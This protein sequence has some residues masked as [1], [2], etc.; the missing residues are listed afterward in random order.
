[1]KTM[2]RHGVVWLFLLALAFCGIQSRAQRATHVRL[3]RPSGS[4]PA[5]ITVSPLGSAVSR[6]GENNNVLILDGFT[7]REVPM[8]VETSYRVYQSRSEQLWSLTRDGMQLFHANEWTLHPIPEIQ[9]ELANN[10]IRQL[11]QINLLPAE[12]SH[13]FILLSDRLLDY[14][15]DTRVTGLLKLASDTK[16]GEFLEIQEGANE[17]I[18]ISG[19]LGFAHLPGP[20][21]RVTRETRWTEYLLPKTN[22]VNTLQRP[23]EYPPGT[24]TASA[25]TASGDGTRFIVQ[26]RGGEFSWLPVP[27]EKI[28][29]G[30]ASWDGSTW[31][32][33]S[34]ALFRIEQGPEEVRLRK[35]PISGAQYDMA[36]EANGVFWIASSEGLLRYAPNLWR[37]PL[38]LEDLQSSIHS[39]AFERGGSAMW[40]ASPEGLIRVR[41]NSIDVFPWPESLENLVPPRASLFPLNGGR[42]LIGTEGRPFLLNAATRQFV[43][44]KVPSAVQVHLLGALSDGRICAWFES[45]AAANADLRAFDG[46]KFEPLVVPPFETK[47]A[48]L[49]V[50]RETARGDLWLGSS[51]GVIHLRLGEGV[52]EY[53]GR[54]QGLSGER[55]ITLE[56]LSEGRMWCGTESHAYEYVQRRWEPRLTNVDRVHS[57]VSALGSV[58]VGTPSAIHRMVKDSW[59]ANGEN[60]GLPSGPVYALEQSLSG[61]L[62]AATS[63]GL[64]TFHADADPDPPKTW[65][66]VVQNPQTPSVLDPTTINFRGNDKWDYTRPGELLF[67]YKL[68]E[69]PWTPFSNQTSRTFQNLSSGTHVIEVR[70]MDRN[71]NQSVGTSQVEFAVIVPWFQDP[72]LLVV[73]VFAGCITMILAAYALMKHLQ[74]KRSYAEV[75]EIVRQRTGE[76]EKANQELLHSQKMRAIGTM[77]AGIAHDFNNILSI[78]KGSAQIIEGNIEDT[79]KI[80]TRVNRIQTVVEQGTTIVKALLG[81][82]RTNAQQLSSCDVGELLHETRRLLSDRFPARVRFQ[83]EL[84]HGSLQTVCSPEVVQQM[85]LNFILNAVEAM[86]GEGIVRLSAHEISSL[87]RE[88]V[89]EPSKAD[90]Y[91]VLT[92]TDTGPGIAPETLARIFEPFFTTKGFS[93]RRGTGLGLS[94]VY[95]LAKGLGYGIAV[96]SEIGKGSSFSILLPVKA[97]TSLA[98]KGEVPGKRA[99]SGALESRR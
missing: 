99:A 52:V 25:N 93:S 47:G 34:T 86:G 92:V 17:S 85:L 27:G 96:R 44:V 73:S 15:A 94:M 6:S 12:V 10:P 77:A 51:R 32:Y 75:E 18:W 26:L 80:K 14:D 42:V 28:K 40:A 55:V 69:A 45:P 59:I 87:R 62:W 90:S 9:Q 5:N 30:W 39:L 78:I 29:Q 23:F 60:E 76:L 49:L 54:E 11:R 22:L 68:D 72:R 91:L 24:V 53:H 19:T 41:P 71:G 16:I 81:L 89:I 83:V 79:E 57:I 46:E 43:A 8:H 58:W 66:P 67:S 98:A 1:M 37:S 82:G 95:E 7:R 70:A 97:E 56:E 3:F 61:E 88:L 64:L 20:M 48:E 36:C 35:E 33:S 65:P 21:R 4:Y 2:R 50:A 84:G 31:G 38:E 13:V 63:R 74:L